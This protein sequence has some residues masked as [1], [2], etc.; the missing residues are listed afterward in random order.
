M[1]P[2]NLQ[3]LAPSPLTETTEFMDGPLPRDQKIAKLLTYLVFYFRAHF[4]FA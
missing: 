3:C 4:A 1:S 2:Q